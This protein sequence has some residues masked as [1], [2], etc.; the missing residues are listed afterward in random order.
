MRALGLFFHNNEIPVINN[1]RW[2]TEETWNYCFDGIPQHSVVAIGTVASGL[3]LLI[4]RPIFEEGLNKMVDVLS[5][6][7]IIVYGSSNYLF[8]DNL[9]KKGI[10][11]LS[12]PSKTSMAFSSKKGGVKHV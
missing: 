12:F 7:T 3:N 5:P 11:I 4:N 8:F 2:G 1:V 10:T 9:R 6:K